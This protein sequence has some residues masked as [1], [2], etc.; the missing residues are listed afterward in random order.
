M[1][2]QEET[3][4]AKV[5]YYFRKEG[6]RHVHVIRRSAFFEI[7]FACTYVTHPGP[8]MYLM[9]WLSSI[10]AFIPIQLGPFE[11]NFYVP[12]MT[13]YIAALL[14]EATKTHRVSKSSLGLRK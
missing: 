10:K 12:L 14:H 3:N 2:A 11:S 4:K 7:Y 8:S 9:T 5:T 1:Q 13:C 6:T